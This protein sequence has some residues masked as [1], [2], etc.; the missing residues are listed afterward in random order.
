M[1]SPTTTAE[2]TVV[3]RGFSRRRQALVLGLTATVVSLFVLWSLNIGHGIYAFVVLGI[4]VVALTLF[5]GPE[6]LARTVTITPDRLRI[7][8]FHRIGTV[9]DRSELAAAEA[10]VAPDRKGRARVVLAL[11]PRDPVGFFT[12]HREL[13]AVRVG[14]AA[15]VPAGTSPQTARELNA[16]LASG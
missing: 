4:A 14:D 16:A 2:R 10:V 11:T 6:R 8:R 5:G 12:S 13:R 15:H 3:T 1:T 9:I 7:E